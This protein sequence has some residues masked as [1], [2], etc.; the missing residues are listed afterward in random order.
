V[1]EVRV[2]QDRDQLVGNID[3]RTGMRDRTNRAFVIRSSR[4]AFV[5]VIGLSESREQDQGD[6]QHR[7]RA[8]ACMRL[9]R[10]FAI[11]QM[12]LTLYQIV[13]IIP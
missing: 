3:E 10:I 11:H 13:E 5:D 2:N 9:H 7:K 8:R 4:I 6:T 12:K 1:R